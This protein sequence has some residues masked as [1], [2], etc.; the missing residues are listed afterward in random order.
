VPV[1][2]ERQV[3]RLNLEALVVGLCLEGFDRAPVKTPNVQRVGH[4]HLRCIKSEDVGAGGGDRS[5]GT[6]GPLVGW[7]E[8]R[9]YER[10]ELAFLGVDLFLRCA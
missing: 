7:I 2:G 9:L 8:V 10:E 6:G 4:L 5:Q 1:R 3:S